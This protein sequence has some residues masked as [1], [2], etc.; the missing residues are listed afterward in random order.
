[1]SKARPYS[2]AISEV[3]ADRVVIRGHDLCS[4]LIGRVSLTEHFLL[5]LTG[6]LP[7]E[8]LRRATDAAMVA[9]AEH[10]F[11]PSVQAARMTLA[12]APEALQGAVAAGLLG[13]GSVV[14]GSA[15]VAGRL[16]AEIAA[17][18]D[19][20]AA[21]RAA[22]VRLRETRATL[23]GFGHPTHKAGDPRAARLVAL[24]HEWG[25]AGRHVAALA[26]L[27]RLVE[28]VYGRALPA[29]VS[30]A[31]PALLLDAGYPAAALKGI[32]VLAR[33]AALIAHLAEETERRL[34]F[35]LADQAIATLAYDGPA[36]GTGR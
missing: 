34:G 30:A 17:E 8:T 6:T 15:E 10:G 20:E 16:L 27:Q 5:L 11:V 2:T 24:A 33:C 4:D 12:G 36:E 14:L 23:P 18:P 3:H 9:I 25:V 35:R 32:P 29:N 13:A 31:I 19:I 21:A 1:M 28:P 22:L 26:A 7:S